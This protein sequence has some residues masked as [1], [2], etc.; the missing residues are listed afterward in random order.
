MRIRV[1]LNWGIIHDK[2][3]DQKVDKDIKLET[4]VQKTIIDK[5]LLKA[6]RYCDRNIVGYIEV[7]DL[8]II[9]HN[10]GKFVE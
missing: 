4:V 6:Y 2:N 3:K 9:L 8:Q 5:E 10:L 1:H 7:E